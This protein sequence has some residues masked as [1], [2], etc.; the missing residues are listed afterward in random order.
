MKSEEKVIQAENKAEN[1]IG[2]YHIFVWVFLYA[3]LVYIGVSFDHEFTYM[4][5]LPILF[6]VSVL[7]LFA[8]LGLYRKIKVEVYSV[9]PN[10]I[11]SNEVGGLI[12]FCWS[13]KNFRILLLSVAALIFLETI[14]LNTLVSIIRPPSGDAVGLVLI[15][16]LALFIFMA[17]VNP[18]VLYIGGSISTKEIKKTFSIRIRMLLCAVF[19]T[20]VSLVVFDAFFPTHA[21]YMVADVIYSLFSLITR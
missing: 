18:L 6:L 1:R 2:I 8:S 10:T 4:L 3:L 15:P 12:S 20:L 5:F 14:F 7:T 11:R 16:M 21:L 13:L 17:I 9:K 19:V